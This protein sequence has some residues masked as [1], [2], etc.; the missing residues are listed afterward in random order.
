M[1]PKKIRLES[2]RRII[3]ENK[4]GSQEELLTILADKGFSATQA[5]LSRDL[6]EL[7][8]V[9]M[10]LVDGYSYK[11][12][13]QAGTIHAS[14]PRATVEGIRSVDCANS[15]VVIKT[16]PAFAGPVSAMID[17]NVQCNAIMG[18]IAGDDTILVILRDPS[19][20]DEALGALNSCF[21]GI[22]NKL[23]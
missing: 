23:K 5:T 12:P 18:T 3:A 19:F 9:K 4:I 17:H 20:K 7:G 22:E 15:F 1:Y 6:R 2:V 21:P 10:H 14:A 13:E 11:L 8:V 16:A